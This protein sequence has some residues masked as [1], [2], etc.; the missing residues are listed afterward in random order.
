MFDN[1]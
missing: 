1:T